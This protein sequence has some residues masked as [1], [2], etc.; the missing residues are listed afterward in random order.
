MLTH[1]CKQ[2]VLTLCIQNGGLLFIRWGTRTFLDKH[3]PNTRE[4]L[5]SRGSIS[6]KVVEITL[7][8]WKQLYCLSLSLSH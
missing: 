2:Q 4:F 1:L 6:L 3:M 7:E 5:F 8:E